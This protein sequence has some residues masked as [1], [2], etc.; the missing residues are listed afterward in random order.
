MPDES[1]T[2]ERVA[3]LVE[4]AL[5]FEGEAQQEFVAHACGEDAAL[6]AEVESLLRFQQEATRFIGGPAYE[7]VAESLASS[8]E[9]QPG[10]RL[11]HYTIRALLGE[12]GMGEVYLAQDE[13]L[14]RQVAIKLIKRAY[15][16]ASFLRQFG[17]EERI[18]AGLTHPHIARLYGGGVTPAGLPFFVMEYVAGE[19]LDV[20]CDLHRLDLRG[21]LALFQKICAAVS[22]AHQHLVIHRD[23][24]P[25]NIRLTPEGEP[26]LLD[27]GIARL[28]DES[29][30]DFTISL[31]KVMTPE[32]A[33]PE[34]IRG[35]RM[36]TASDVYSLGV[37][38]YELLAGEK[39]FRLTSRRAEEAE[40][41]ICET[42]PPPPSQGRPSLPRDLDTIVLMAMRKEPERRYA[43]AAALS[44][45]LQRFLEG[46]PV[47]ARKDTWSYRSAR[48][49]QR[50]KLTAAGTLLLLITLLAGIFA[51]SWQAR[52]AEH[53]RALAERR[54]SELRGLAHALMFEIHDAV[55]DLPGSTTT[56]QLIVTR[57]LA[58][59]NSLAQEAGGDPS[60]SRE[61]AN[62]YIR[63]GNVQGNPNNSNLGDIDGALTTFATAREIAERLLAVHPADAQAYR[64]LGVIDEKMSEVQAA[65]G[66]L[67]AAVASAQRSLAVFRSLAAQ[68]PGDPAAQQALAISSLK[69]AD[70]LGHPNFPNNG[71]AAGALRLYQEAL[72]ILQSI[73]AGAG[74]V[75][76]TTRLTGLLHERLG[77]MH[78]SAGHLE[79]AR[80]A[81]AESQRI[82]LELAAAHRDHFDVVRDAAVAD[83]KVANVLEASG[84]LAGALASRER[85]LAVFQHLAEID[86]KNT[87]AQRSLALSHQHMAD[88]LG[89][90]GGPNLGRTAEALEH[91]RAAEAI[92]RPLPPEP[93][94][95]QTLAAIEGPL[96]A[97]QA[98]P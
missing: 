7:L 73:P 72:A 17:K 70:V 36:T 45:D 89:Q 4:A 20:W 28:I 11:E 65:K 69:T 56:R 59:L 54:F 31:T 9:L 10:E 90:P 85:S 58:Y 19:R 1:S 96:R 61:L 91:Y 12:G 80:R 81:Y 76:K 47:L 64:I 53:A 26:K 18:L 22:Y 93:I 5:E 21:R 27:F 63:V 62:A 49:L 97:L 77:T 79:E 32:Y 87:S 46:R 25:A 41:T 92:L 52:Q 75:F 68:A 94:R 39:P 15:G 60:L 71:D 13:E 2:A 38:L 8:S 44:A 88:L 14:G 24:K 29:A 48:F 30:D 23:L 67:R 84:D 95:D 86:P 34:Q 42:E 51:T 83:E 33:S 40:R 55:A 57:A 78:E 50:N 35:E 37:I 98:R 82:R 74:D 43:S 66:D 3:E 6:R 16:R